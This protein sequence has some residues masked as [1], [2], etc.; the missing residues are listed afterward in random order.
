MDEL[1]YLCEDLSQDATNQDFRL[2]LTTMKTEAFSV[3]TL[4]LG[5]KVAIE[6]PTIVK[7]SLVRHHDLSLK[8]TFDA[9]FYK[10]IPI[11]S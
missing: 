6:E 8:W 9:F 1:E 5:V 3:P 10:K 11:L 2:W 4:Q 7:T